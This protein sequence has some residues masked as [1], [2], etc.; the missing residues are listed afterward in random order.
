MALRAVQQATTPEM[1]I[2]GTGFSW[3]REYG[4][5]IAAGCIEQGWM[6]IACFGRQAFAYPDF[7][8]DI[9][10]RGMKSGLFINF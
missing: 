2:T 9:V 6:D 5:I 10:T 8:R 1:I 4:A 7:T 3:F